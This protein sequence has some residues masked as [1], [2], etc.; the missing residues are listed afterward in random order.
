MAN[1]AIIEKSLSNLSHEINAVHGDVYEV[2]GDVARVEQKLDEL[3]EAFWAYVEEDQAAKA[4]QLAHTEIIQLQQQLEK[5]FGHYDE[6]RRYTTG[7]LQAVDINVVRKETILHCTETLMLNAPKYWLAPCLIA[8]AAWISDNRELADKALKEA[9]RRDDE[10]TSLL[11]ALITRRAGRY[12]SCLQWLERY[13]SMQNPLHM[14]SK[15]II[16]LEAFSSGL[17]GPDLK[18]LCEETI[19][20][21][22]KE[23]ENQPDFTEQQKEQ[24][25]EA[26]E[27]RKVQIDD[28]ETRFLSS[29]VTNWPDMK[30][31]LEWARTHKEIKVYFE[32]I[33]NKE[34]NNAAQVEEQVDYLLTDL[35]TNFDK[36]E[37]P[38]RRE[39]KKNEL[40]IKHKG[41]IKGLEDKIK[42]K[43]NEYEQP[44]D[45]SQHLTDVAMQR[46]D[47]SVYPSTQKLAIAMSKDW[48]KES[49]EDLTA[50]YR[51]Q[52]PYE[53]ELSI[54]GWT[55]I[56]TDGYNELELL[57]SLHNAIDT[58]FVNEYSTLKVGLGTYVLIALT[59]VS[60]LLGFGAP[61]LFIGTAILALCVYGTV[62][63]INTKREEL[64]ARYRDYQVNL[65]GYLQGTL[66]EFVDYQR[67]FNMED[68]NA[69]AVIEFLDGLSTKHFIMNSNDAVRQVIR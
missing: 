28:G 69:E 42:E 32:Q 37:L 23:L 56:T 36:E 4:L 60:I 64:C 13:F 21:W 10:K 67:E 48:I 41:H 40:I 52:M 47:K 1:L 63:G 18:G 3:T 25:S 6:V 19:M 44:V 11:F 26:L 16:I 5:E 33:I 49:Y 68:K 57:E 50:M 2:Q 66:A 9:L 59:V 8:L 62:G 55:G 17:F 58:A 54:D 45:F 24:W 7:I 31:A 35:V 27:E 12:E 29:Y 53:Y 65:E 38:L 43:A 46:R 22:M 51:M 39:I 61:W 15:M 30:A 34:Q 20:S 14:E